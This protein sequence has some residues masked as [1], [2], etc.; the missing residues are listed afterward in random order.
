MA[1]IERKTLLAA[2]SAIL[3]NLASVFGYKPN[4]KNVVSKDKAVL[5]SGEGPD[6]EKIMVELSTSSVY[7]YPSHNQRKLGRVSGKMTPSALA[8]TYIK[9]LLKISR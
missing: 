8:V 3:I 6:E 9:Q 1:E 4:N 2:Q 7:H 5:Y